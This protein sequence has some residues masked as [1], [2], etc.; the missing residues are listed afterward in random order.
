M[1]QIE[2]WDWAMKSFKLYL[3][4][5]K[6]ILSF[7]PIEVIRILKAAYRK[8]SRWIQISYLMRMENPDCD[9]KTRDLAI[10]RAQQVNEELTDA[11]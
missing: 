2:Y 7:I 9:L 6:N 11:A 8:S 4:S 1:N 5:N 10:K 3:N